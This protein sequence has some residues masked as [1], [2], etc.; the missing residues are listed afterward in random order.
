MTNRFLISAAAIALLAS[1]G[2]ANAQGTGMG[3]E[4]GGAAQQSSMPPG[5]TAWFCPMHPEVTASDA[6]RCRKCGMALV[7]GDPFDTREYGVELSTSPAAIKP[8]VPATLTLTIRHPGTGAIITPIFQT[9]TYVQ[10]ALG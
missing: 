2:F 7:A 5:F 1:G 3:R 9:S 10:D 6:G 8:G 4:S